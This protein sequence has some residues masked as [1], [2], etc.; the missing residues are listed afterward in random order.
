L[1]LRH[2]SRT[3]AGS[4]LFALA[5]SITA[6]GSNHIKDKKK[7]PG[8]AASS[9][10]D[11]LSRVRTMGAEQPATTGSLWVSSGPLSNASAD[12]KARF[13]GDLITVQ[14]VDTFSAA[15]T[16]ENNTS[17]QFATQSAITGLLGKIGPNNAMQNLLAANSN[18]ALDGKGSSTMSSNLQLNLAGRV[19]EVMP[20]GVL[21]VEAAR[22]FTVGNDRQTVVLRGLVRPGD[23]APNNSVV[24]SAIT[25]LELE[26]KGKGS[27]ADASARPN[28]L[29]RTVLK[30]LTF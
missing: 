5:V 8:P 11:Y 18:T 25:S 6:A 30:L 4:L 17:R 2:I 10:D 24:S 22:D 15:T 13:A 20:N 9:L 26:I 29:V 21:V 14:L 3:L 12:Y 27:V 23:I 16:G 7:K 1:I 19:V 28:I